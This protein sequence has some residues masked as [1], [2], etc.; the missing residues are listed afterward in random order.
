MLPSP[1]SF[2]MSVHVPLQVHEDWPNSK[3]AQFFRQYQNNNS[4]FL[5]TGQVTFIVIYAY[6]NLS[7]PASL[8][9]LL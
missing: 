7:R 9:N 6:V 3:Q 4:L 1:H 2:L 8:S 5:C